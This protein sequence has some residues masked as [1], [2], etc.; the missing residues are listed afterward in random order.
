M[1]L[2]QKEID[3]KSEFCYQKIILNNL[4]MSFSKKAS[5][6]KIK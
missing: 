3:K 5:V 4:W 1:L 6:Y 2:W